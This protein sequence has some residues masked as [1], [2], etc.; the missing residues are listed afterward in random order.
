MAISRNFP[1]LLVFCA[2]TLSVAE[3]NLFLHQK[4]SYHQGCLKF[5]AFTVGFATVGLTSEVI[6]NFG[7]HYHMIDYR[8]VYYRGVYFVSI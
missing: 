4:R 8:G 5:Y 7:I 6:Y 1:R 2:K 3:K